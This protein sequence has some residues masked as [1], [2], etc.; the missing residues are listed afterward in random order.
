MDYLESS[1]EISKTLDIKTQSINEKQGIETRITTI[2]GVT[3]IEVVDDTRF[4]TSFDY[5]DGFVGN[6]SKIN[7]LIA[8]PSMVKTV[9]KISSIK[10]WANGTHTEG[11]GDLYQRRE[12]WDTFV[13]PNGLD[14]KCDAVYVNIE[15]ND[16]SLANYPGKFYTVAGQKINTEGTGA[17]I[18]AGG[19][20]GV[21]YT[22]ALSGKPAK[23]TAAQI[24]AIGWNEAVKNAAVFCVEIGDND[25]YYGRGESKVTSGMSAITDN[26]VV[27][28]GGTRYLVVAKGLKADKSMDG[29][30]YFSVGTAAATVTKSYIIDTS[31]LV[32]A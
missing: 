2:N 1:T 6:G 27:T 25:A 28:I 29:G 23:V 11:D 26:D 21:D 22:I 17:E 12:Y 7:V 8:H 9:N 19:T 13:F 15:S 31:A 10:F 16:P 30:A 24:S 18:S 14:G 3:I 32:L 20:G 4:N 5:S